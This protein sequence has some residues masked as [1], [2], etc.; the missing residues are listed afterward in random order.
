M[1]SNPFVQ[2][3]IVRVPLSGEEFIDI[4][5]ELNAGEQ[6]LVFAGLV[7]DMTLGESIRLVPEQVGFTKLLA[8]LVG[9]SFVDAEGKPVPVSK[10]AVNSLN[11]ETYAEI[12]AAIDAHEAEIEKARAMRKN[13]QTG[14]TPLKV[15]SGSR[16]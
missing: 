11:A 4:K 15:I 12:I 13:D 2:P 1:S 3:R 5:A 10:D 14:A 16:G 8:Y 7:R 6:R 9:W